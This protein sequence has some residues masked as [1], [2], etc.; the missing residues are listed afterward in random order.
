[1]VSIL[2]PAESYVYSQLGF[3]TLYD[4]FGV[5]RVFERINFYKH[6]IP[7]GLGFQKCHK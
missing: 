6:A 4:S 1:M 5:E 2:T 3:R 7:S